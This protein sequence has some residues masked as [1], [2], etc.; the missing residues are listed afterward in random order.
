MF[1]F[2]ILTTES[3]INFLS[4]QKRFFFEFIFLKFFLLKFFFLGLSQS[5]KDFF[6]EFFFE[7]LFLKTTITNYNNYNNSITRRQKTHRKTKI[8]DKSSRSR[9]QPS[10]RNT[11]IHLESSHTQATE[12]GEKQKINA[13]RHIQNTEKERVIKNWK[14][15]DLSKAT[16]MERKENTNGHDTTQIYKRPAQQ[17]NVVKTGKRK[18]WTIQRLR[19]PIYWRVQKRRRRPSQS[20]PK[21]KL[22]KI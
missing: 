15:D 4:I 5:R 13:I 12:E 8:F 7:V 2:W 16:S 19:H 14:N 21:Q 9:E 11:R 3:T 22:Y 10:W 1:L 18:D 17:R 20:L 6:F